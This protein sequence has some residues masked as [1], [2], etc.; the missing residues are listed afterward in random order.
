MIKWDTESFHEVIRLFTASVPPTRIIR[1]GEACPLCPRKCRLLPQKRTL[2]SVS[3]MSAL[4]R[5][6]TYV[7]AEPLRLAAGAR[8]SYGLRHGALC[9]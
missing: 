5:K 1:G 2:D 3:G 8:I 7:S 9:A 4:G 6:Q